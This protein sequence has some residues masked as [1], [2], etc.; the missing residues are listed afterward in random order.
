[1]RKLVPL[2][3]IYAFV[4]VAESGSMTEAAQ[5]LSVSHSAISQA[6][7]SLES[8]VNK[9][10]FDRIGRHVYLNTEGKKYYRKV[11]PALEQIVD[12][13]EALMHDQ[14]S[15]RI[16]LN[17]VNSLALHWWIP[18]MPRLQAYAPQLDVRLSNLSGRFNLEQEGVDAALVHGNTEEWQDYYCEKLSEDELVLVCSP[19]LIDHRN[20]INLSDI[21]KTYPLIEV[22]NERRKHDWQVWSDATGVARPKNK[23][24]ITFN[25]SIQAV[26]ATTRRLGVLVTHRLFVKDDIKY[27]QLIE[28]GEPVI[29]PN[30]QL[31]FVC[32]PHK[33]KQESFHLL[34]LWLN[35]NLRN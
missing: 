21:L 11:A 27:G 14:N 12:A 32:P 33:L 2:K 7:K 8:Q 31:Y 24:P 22:T 1:M 28:L 18:R 5:L 35:K 34:R 26:Q 23:K 29:N 15:Q 3:S 13:T 16:T 25:M 4:A 6:I 17:M 9:P 20:P 19:D 10:L 30:Q